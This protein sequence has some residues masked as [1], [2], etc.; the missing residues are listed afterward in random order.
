MLSLDVSVEGR[1]FSVKLKEGAVN[2]LLVG[3][4]HIDAEIDV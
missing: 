3:V 2:S 4:M 1:M